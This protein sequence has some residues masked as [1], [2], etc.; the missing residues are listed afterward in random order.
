MCLIVSFFL[1][2]VTII[3]DT[4]IIEMHSKSKNTIVNNFFSRVLKNKQ[5][6]FSLL[7]LRS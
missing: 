1:K 7:S 4:I 3:K 5:N 6:Q 2:R